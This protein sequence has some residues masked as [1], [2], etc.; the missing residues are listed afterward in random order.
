MNRTTIIRYLNSVMKNQSISEKD[1]IIRIT[2]ELPIYLGDVMIGLLL[3]DGSLERTSSTSGV[4]LS[5]S[6]SE[7]HKEYLEFLY[8]LYEP[9]INTKPALIKVYN[10]KTDSYNNVLKFKTL[11][12]PQLIYYYEL[13]YVEGKKLIPSN[14]EDLI[15]PVGLAHLI[16]GDGNLKQ[17]DK[18]IRI[19]TNSFTK[20]DVE[21]LAL[22]I[23]NKFNIKTRVVHD[24]NNQYIITI[25]KSEL[26][27]V[28]S[29]IK[30]HLHPSMFYKID[31]ENNNLHKFDY[32][33]KLYSF[34]NT[35][36]YYK[37]ILDQ[38][39]K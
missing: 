9:Y 8:K 6:F 33:D 20:K 22:A 12:L 7:K 24:R 16:M 35:A 25:S 36:V 19:Y 17:P 23:I 3:S 28:N 2:N 1:K 13:F 14:V 38:Y 4:R 18:I 11:T 29:L 39:T 27:K 30:D 32:N 5:I 37:D 31:L 34:K 21:L 10:K 15:T 26:P